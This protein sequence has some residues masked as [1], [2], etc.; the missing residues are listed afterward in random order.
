MTKAGVAGPVRNRIDLHLLLQR[1]EMRRISTGMPQ[2]FF[3]L[4]TPDPHAPL[5]ARGGSFPDLRAALAEANCAARAL[6]HNRVRRA[7]VELHG[8]LDIED[9]RRQPI[10]R[11]LLADV[12]RQIS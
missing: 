12:A 10:A 5:A 8:S 2:Y 11:I 1:T 3:N 9:E 4:R 7:P 6:I